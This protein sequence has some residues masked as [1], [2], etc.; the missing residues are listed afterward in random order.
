[1]LVIPFL[2]RSVPASKISLPAFHASIISFALPI[3]STIDD[4][5]ST[6]PKT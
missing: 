5:L 2:R 4:T 6:I 1:M 3:P